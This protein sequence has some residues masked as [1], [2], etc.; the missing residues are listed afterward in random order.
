MPR[1]SQRGTGFDRPLVLAIYVA[2]TAL[3]VATLYVS[4]H[5]PFYGALLGV[6]APIKNGLAGGIAAGVTAVGIY[7]FNRRHASRER[8][9]RL[10]DM[11]CVE[12]TRMSD[13]LHDRAPA[14]GRGWP[15]ARAVRPPAWPDAQPDGSGHAQRRAA[16]VRG[17]L[18]RGESWLAYAGLLSSGNLSHFE[19][20]LQARLH[21]LY[22]RARQ[23]EYDAAGR[24]LPPLI[25]DAVAFREAN[26]PF[27]PSHLARPVS[28]ALSSLRGKWRV[29]GRPGT[30]TGAP[31]G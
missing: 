31:A 10:A 21:A 30:G 16:P 4:Q 28:L 3:A 7:L 24:L 18:P 29:H 20:E 14:V 5:P 17:H 12:M 19:P 25:R 26:A 13:A 23:G 9:F 6:I 15:K 11:L 27:C 1:P 8:K 2:A 22:S